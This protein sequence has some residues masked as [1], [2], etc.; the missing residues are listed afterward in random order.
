L[1]NAGIY[2]LLLLDEVA[3]GDTES[4]KRDAIERL[5][6]RSLATSARRFDLVDIGPPVS[7]QFSAR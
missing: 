5:P 3:V 1:S 6:S 4:L 2:V 7:L